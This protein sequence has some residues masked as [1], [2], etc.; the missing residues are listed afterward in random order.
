[1]DKTP[2]TDDEGK[3]DS[4]FGGWDDDEDKAYMERAERAQLR[5]KGKNPKEVLRGGAKGTKEGQNETEKLDVKKELGK[6]GRSLA[7]K[8]SGKAKGA[9]IKPSK[10]NGDKKRKSI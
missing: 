9:E 7:K 2:I 3:A 4:D 5:K 1:V 10:K 8:T 6:T